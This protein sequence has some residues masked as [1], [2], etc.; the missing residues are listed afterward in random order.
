MN[1]IGKI[2]VILNFLFAIIVGALLVVDFA[3]RN[4]WK[5]AYVEL[6]QNVDVYVK[7]QSTTVK[8]AQS[9]GS[10]LT[11]ALAKIDEQNGKIKDAAEEAKANEAKYALKIQD[12]E[13][14]LGTSKATLEQSVAS[15]KRLADEIVDLNKTIKLR[16]GQIVK[17]E[18]DVKTY[19]LSALNFEALAN[20]RQIKNENLLEKIRD[21]TTTLARM[22]AGVNPNTSVIRN[23]NEPNPPAVMVNGKIE[24]VD[25]DLVQISLGTDQGVNKNNTLDVYRTNPEAKY[26]GMVRIVDANA[27]KSVAR[28]IVIGTG[29]RPQLKEGDLVTSKITNK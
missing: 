15:T 11:E 16:E 27:H 12:L 22:E 29:A 17:L 21:L 9:I 3:A 25:A 5:E 23:P 6:K 19:R 13:L 28:F 24:K 10:E 14:Q 2:L 20:G 8:A 1:T 26:L 18:T 7:S 4:K